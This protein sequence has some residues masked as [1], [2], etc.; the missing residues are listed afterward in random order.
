MNNNALGAAKQKKMFNYL[1]KIRV[2][3]HKQH[4]LNDH[5]YNANGHIAMVTSRAK[6]LK[7]YFKNVK[8]FQNETNRKAI[9]HKTKQL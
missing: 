8:F 1:V 3:W 2:T 6:M 9:K 5:N 4:T 7:I